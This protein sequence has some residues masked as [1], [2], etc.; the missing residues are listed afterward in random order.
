MVSEGQCCGAPA[1]GAEWH[2][3]SVFNTKRIPQAV[4]AAGS[5][6][7]HPTGLPD[8]QDPTHS[9]FH[10]ASFDLH[11]GHTEL[12]NKNLFKASGFMFYNL[13]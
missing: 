2:F 10:S 7:T 4:P 5:P 3:H 12:E 6:P 13:P 11:P 9:M 1:R 8:P